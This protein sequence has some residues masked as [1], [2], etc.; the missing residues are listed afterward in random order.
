M[1]AKNY[2]NL[3]DKNDKNDMKI[4]FALKSTAKKTKQIILFI[5]AMQRNDHILLQF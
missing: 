3:N 5:M 2:R 4:L 1:P